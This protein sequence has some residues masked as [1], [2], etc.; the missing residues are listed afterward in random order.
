VIDSLA[1]VDSLRSV[2]AQ[3]HSL[4]ASLR[5][6]N[7]LFDPRW[8]VGDVLQALYLA[9]T[10]CIFLATLGAVRSSA[11]QAKASRELLE[12]ERERSR[13]ARAK[14]REQAKPIFVSNGRNRSGASVSL[15]FFNRGAPVRNLRVKSLDPGVSVAFSPEPYF[16]PEVEGRLDFSDA[17]RRPLVFWVH[18]D[19]PVGADTMIL[20]IRENDDFRIAGYASDSEE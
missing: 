9:A 10:V 8:T 5:A 12:L 20:E 18:F 3:R 15:R 4:V 17:G 19:T 16:G 11:D 2:I 6:A 7:K 13:R 14:E 1:V